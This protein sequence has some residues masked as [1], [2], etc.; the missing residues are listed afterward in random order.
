MEYNKLVQK[1]TEIKEE[2]ERE[3]NLADLYARYSNLFVVAL[4]NGIQDEE[5]R[6]LFEIENA[7]KSKIITD[8]MNSRGYYRDFEDDWNRWERKI[9]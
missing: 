1:L 7:L 2:I 8:Y 5:Y 9:T 3:D 4:D 6:L